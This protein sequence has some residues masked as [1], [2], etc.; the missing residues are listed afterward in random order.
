MGHAAR[1]HVITLRLTEE[2]QDRVRQDAESRKQSI[3]QFVRDKVT[4]EPAHKPAS[5][6]ARPGEQTV[7]GGRTSL[8]EGAFWLGASPEQQTSG[9][10]LTLKSQR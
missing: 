5:S 10:N 8:S 9:Q 4:K 2:E 7:S 6:I 1:S 3:S